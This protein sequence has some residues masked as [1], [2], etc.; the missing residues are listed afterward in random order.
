ML[1][2]S[3]RMPVAGGTG[4]AGNRWESLAAINAI[5]VWHGVWLWLVVVGE[6][7]LVATI[8]FASEGFLV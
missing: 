5:E 6:R 4:K 2:S 3:V 1:A 8:L 7:F